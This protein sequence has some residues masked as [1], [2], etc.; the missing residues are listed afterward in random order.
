MDTELFREWHIELLAA[1]CESFTEIERMAANL[2]SVIRSDKSLSEGIVDGVA[3]VLREELELLQAEVTRK[4]C[5]QLVLVLASAHQILTILVD[6]LVDTLVD[7]NRLDS[8]LAGLTQI[9]G[10]LSLVAI[11]FEEHAIVLECLKFVRKDIEAV[12][13]GLLTGKRFVVFGFAATEFDLVET[14]TGISLDTSPELVLWADRILLRSFRVDILAVLGKVAVQDI[15]VAL[16]PAGDELVVLG[17]SIAS[18]EGMR[19]AVAPATVAVEVRPA[20]TFDVVKVDHLFVFGPDKLF[21]GTEVGILVL[22][23]ALDHVALLVVSHLRLVTSVTKLGFLLGIFHEVRIDG[24][25]HV[26]LDAV[27]LIL[28]LINEEHRDKVRSR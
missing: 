9:T 17:E 10:R 25:V 18:E 26:L 24:L 28:N 4:V 23:E 2:I 11:A 7:V 12:W 15:A 14:L 22:V 13:Q 3:I 6:E 21:D 1:E 5:A 27:G 8:E 20:R 16:F 19:P